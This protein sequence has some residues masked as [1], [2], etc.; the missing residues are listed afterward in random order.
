M[1][2]FA[3]KIKEHWYAYRNIYVCVGVFIITVVMVSSLALYLIFNAKPDVTETQPI[4]LEVKVFI[5]DDDTIM[6]KIHD[7]ISELK[8]AIDSMRQDTLQITIVKGK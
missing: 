2:L 5:N 3:S 6:P 7:D 8:N 4:P 1:K